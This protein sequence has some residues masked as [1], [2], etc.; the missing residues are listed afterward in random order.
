MIMDR[1]LGITIVDDMG[2]TMKFERYKDSQYVKKVI[3]S[4]EGMILYNDKL[5]EF[6]DWAKKNWEDGLPLVNLLT[7]G[8]YVP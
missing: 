1:I 7:N 6:K 8:M 2:Y 3:V 4:L 5:A